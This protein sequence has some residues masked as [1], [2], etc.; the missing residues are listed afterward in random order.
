MVAIMLLPPFKKGMF[1]PLVLFI[2]AHQTLS[3]QS[4]S[5]TT[6][7]RISKS[8]GGR[9]PHSPDSSQALVVKSEHLDE[10]EDRLQYLPTPIMKKGKGNLGTRISSP[11]V[12][13]SDE[14]NAPTPKAKAKAKLAKSDSP[15]VISSD[16]SD[17]PTPKPKLKKNNNT[18]TSSSDRLE[19]M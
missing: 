8:T 18:V 5:K 16:E 17:A 7:T 9:I 15:I 3:K 10:D 6:L 12:I 19:K 2:D 1:N 11:V 14:S 13:S 4:P